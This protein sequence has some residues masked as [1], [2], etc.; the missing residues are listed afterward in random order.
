MDSDNLSTV[1]K[2]RMSALEVQE[3][4]DHYKKMPIQ[5]IEYIHANQLTFIQGNLIKYTTRYPHKGSAEADLRKIIHYAQLA[6]HLE[7]GEGKQ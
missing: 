5:P 4:G 2:E 1:A 3:S 7:Y 6:L